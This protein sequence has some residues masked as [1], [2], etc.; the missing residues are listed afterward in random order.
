M[1]GAILNAPHHLRSELATLFWFQTVLYL[2]RISTQ[3]IIRRG[4]SFATWLTF[5]SLPFLISVLKNP[6]VGQVLQHTPMENG[7]H[8]AWTMAAAME[9]LNTGAGKGVCDRGLLKA[10]SVA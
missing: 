4:S 10:L 2:S 3:H 9:N 7:K 6:F 8:R 1:A 5:G